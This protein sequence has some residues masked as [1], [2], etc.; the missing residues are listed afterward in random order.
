MNKTKKHRG[1]IDKLTSICVVLTFFSLWTSGFASVWAE[2]LI[3]FVLIFTFGI[4][5]GANDLFILSRLQPGV[6]KTKS[7]FQ[8]LLIYVAV[9]LI[10]ALIFYFIPAFALAF[11]ILFSAYHFG[12]Q[13]WH[14]KFTAAGMIRGL[15]FFLYGAAVLFLIFWAHFEEVNTVIGGLGVRSFPEEFY[16]VGFWIALAGHFLILISKLHWKRIK[17]VLPL[18]LLLWAVFWIVFHNASLILSFAIYFI[19]WH[20]LPSLLDQIHALYGAFNRKSALQYLRSS[21]L[22]WVLALTGLAVAFLTIEDTDG[23]FLSLFFSF[24]AA[25]TFPH[26]VVMVLMNRS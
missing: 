10:A 21:A 20:A 6:L 25:I 3:A 8:V 4:L 17:A 22:Y 11:F 14:R 15:F 2:Q 23:N 16:S 12:E 26:V 13:H 7:S 1:Q 18:E 9:V 19:L 5:H 24:L